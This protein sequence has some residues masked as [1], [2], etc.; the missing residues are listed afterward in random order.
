M[1]LVWSRLVGRIQGL[2]SKQLPV[3]SL[4]ARLASGA[5]WSILG[6]GI[7][8]GL[9]FLAS[10]V[11]AWFLK[12]AGFGK[13]GMVQS[14]V[15][16][17]GALA[18]MGLGTT[19]M[20]HIAEFRNIDP[21]K[22][23]RIIAMASVV[24]W[25]AAGLIA[26]AVLFSA[27]IIAE[28]AMK[29][30]DG[31]FDS[32]LVFTLQLACILL[33][34]NAVNGAQMGA[35]TGMEAFRAVAKINVIRG[36]VTLPFMVVG[37]KLAGLN[38]VVLANAAAAGAICA[39]SFF[40]VRYEARKAGIPIRYSHLGRE[41]HILWRFAVPA[42]LS[43]LVFAPVEPY[44]FSVLIKNKGWSELGLFNATKQWNTAILYLPTLAAQ[45]SLPV[46]ANL[47]GENQLAK[48][49]RVL[50]INSLI[51]TGCAAVVAIP[52]AIASPWV[53]SV[54]GHGFKGGWLVLV[55][56]CI[57]SIFWAANIVVGQAI[58]AANRPRAGMIFG[59]IRSVVLIGLALLLM[60]WGAVG[61][62][63]AYAIACLLQVIYQFPYMM[64][65]LR[66]KQEQIRAPATLTPELVEK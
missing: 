38:G 16:M 7:S 30:P 40:L 36:V 37:L 56:T 23:G 51:F 15:G 65:L 26:L 1:S 57:Y 49:R 9:T 32:S 41:A 35:L 46:L 25:V 62:A 33:L 27:G 8:Q 3:D 55:L 11:A 12:E 10:I 19:A 48:Y 66:K 61:L 47:W 13:W 24:S 14:T 45:I 4:R 63:A 43:S 58:W 17:F 18:G 52:V 53:M 2:I 6:A 44:L 20:K 64:G 60:P 54:Y 34:F 42:L 50:I 29:A 5:F 28:H 22:A 59:A 39:A 21:A 31:A